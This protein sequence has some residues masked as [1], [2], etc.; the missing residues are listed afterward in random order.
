V[1][2]VAQ[3]VLSVPPGVPLKPGQR[4]LWTGSYESFGR[5][6]NNVPVCTG[7][8]DNP[9][10]F[11]G[12]Y[13][14]G[15][16]FEHYYA[17]ARYYDPYTG[18]FLSR[19][20]ADFEYDKSP[21]AINRYP[22]AGNNPIRYVDPNGE[23]FFAAILGLVWE[24]IVAD[25]AAYA[26]VG[27]VYELAQGGDFG[28][29]LGGFVR[30]GFIGAISSLSAGFVSE[31]TGAAEAVRTASVLTDYQTMT[32]AA[33]MMTGT[34]QMAMMARYGANIG[35]EG[36]FA[37]AGHHGYWGLGLMG[38]GSWIGTSGFWGSFVFG[39]GFL[40]VE[41]DFVQHTVLQNIDPTWVSPMH[42]FFA[43]VMVPAGEWI[44]ERLGM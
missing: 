9:I 31:F 21:I 43:N 10:Q 35:G 41:D 2:V 27:G 25:V 7:A 3:P 18:R 37:F 26:I 20:P 11:T 44:L 33:G 22:Y 13:N 23:F 8:F 29:F 36:P 42:V 40:M 28:D 6:D 4:I 15:D 16:V 12:Y 1:A 5:P 34:N 38:L 24:A 17:R 39:M 30:G 14:D 19:D 32:V